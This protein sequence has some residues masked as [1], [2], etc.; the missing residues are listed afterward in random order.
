MWSYRL[1]KFEAIQVL[2]LKGFPWEVFGEYFE[3][4]KWRFFLAL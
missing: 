4:N 3:T 2:Q 1:P